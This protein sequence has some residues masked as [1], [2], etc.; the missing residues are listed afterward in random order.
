LHR[1]IPEFVQPEFVQQECVGDF[2]N[3]INWHNL[4]PDA[5]AYALLPDA[6]NRKGRISTHDFSWDQ[7]L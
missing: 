4:L 3:S 2:G 7:H 5:A 1:R 6:K